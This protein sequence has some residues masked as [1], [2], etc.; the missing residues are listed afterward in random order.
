[1][2]PKEAYRYICAKFHGEGASKNK[3]E[4]RKRRELEEL[5]VKQNLNEGGKLLKM[6]EQ[7]QEKTNEAHLVLNIGGKGPK[8][9]WF[10]FAS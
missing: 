3:I 1:M 7:H 4:I 8:T 5:R 10:N 6:L 2:K 9:T